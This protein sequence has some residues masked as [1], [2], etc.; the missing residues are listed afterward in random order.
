MCRLLCNQSNDNSVKYAGSVVGCNSVKYAG[1]V[2]GC[3]STKYAGSVVGC[4]SVKY[5]GSVVGCKKW[6]LSCYAR[7]VLNSKYLDS[8]NKHF[9]LINCV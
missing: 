1:S 3:N 5:A 9:K 7:R 2:V 8:Y 6:S 4:N